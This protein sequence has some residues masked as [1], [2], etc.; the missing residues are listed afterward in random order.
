[1]CSGGGSRGEEV[2][3]EED[4]DVQGP[5]PGGRAGVTAQEDDLRVN[6]RSHSQFDVNFVFST[7]ASI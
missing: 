3:C 2:E 4:G 5:L 7:C 6:V 1:M